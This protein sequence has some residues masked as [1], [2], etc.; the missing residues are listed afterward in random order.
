MYRVVEDEWPSVLRKMPRFIS[1]A[2]I[3]AAANVDL[4]TR[5]MLQKLLWTSGADS[6]RVGLGSRG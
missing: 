6:V 5:L 3:K 1:N 2:V 4:Y